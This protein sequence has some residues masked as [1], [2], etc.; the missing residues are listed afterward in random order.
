MP[1]PLWLDVSRWRRYR[2]SLSAA[3]EPPSPEL[4]LAA[5]V[6]DHGLSRVLQVS[7]GSA[8]TGHMTSDRDPVTKDRWVR[9][10]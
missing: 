1:P 4:E 3:A 7:G 9:I 2:R 6:L 10:F 5:L 8:H